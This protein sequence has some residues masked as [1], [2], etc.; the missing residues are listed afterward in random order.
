MEYYSD[1]IRE[2]SKIIPELNDKQMT[3]WNAS[4]QS[5]IY[6]DQNTINYFYENNQDDC[7]LYEKALNEF[8]K[9]T[10]NTTK[11]QG[12][13]EQNNVDLGNVITKNASNKL[14][15]ELFNSIAK[16]AEL[17]KSDEFTAN[18]HGHMALLF[19]AFNDKEE[20]FLLHR[21][22]V[23]R[24]NKNDSLV[25]WI[26]QCAKHL[27]D[28]EDLKLWG[29][30]LYD[31]CE[32]L[33][34]GNAVRA[35]VEARLDVAMTL[36]RRTDRSSAD[37]AIRLEAWLNG[38][39]SAP[40]WQAQALRALALLRIRENRWPDAVELLQEGAGVKPDD[41]D[42][43]ADLCRALLHLGEAGRERAE[44]EARAALSGPAG[45]T[46]P[47]WALRQLAVTL[48]AKGDPPGAAEAARRAVRKNPYW[49]EGWRMLSLA[50]RDTDRD[51]ALSH[52]EKAVEVAP[53]SFPCIVHLCDL[54]QLLGE[55]DKA[56]AAAENSLREW[57]E[58][59]GLHIFIAEILKKR[60]DMEHAVA[61]AFKA[62]E[63]DPVAVAHRIFLASLLI[64]AGRTAE[65][66]AVAHDGMARFP[67]AGWPHAVF[68]QALEAENDMPGA[69]AQARLSLAKQPHK[70]SVAANYARLLRTSGGLDD[71]EEFCRK[72]LEEDASQGW[73]W[74][75]LCRSAVARGDRQAALHYGGKALEAHPEDMEFRHYVA[76]LKTT[77]PS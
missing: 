8:K 41:L 13:P 48:D 38:L 49:G 64:Q 65:A 15:T 55:E 10:Q 58:R 35:L 22:L 44:A 56:M 46:E 73:A 77:P 47:E 36:A 2:L 69:L 24:I 26:F 51:A 54:L 61:H 71:C 53:G 28:P 3:I 20:F 39:R 42:L 6:I 68:S 50:C 7:I 75:E 27:A 74:R 4:E 16:N 66:V 23:D 60:G 62:V 37:F 43:R 11:M 29:E 19:Y 18:T 59:G 14:F 1:S 76:D 45:T 34:P 5:E 32:N 52:A 17:H 40:P 70:R 30:R 12:S 25:Y 31:A 67:D 9:R 63:A 72:A 21:W 57:P 33:D